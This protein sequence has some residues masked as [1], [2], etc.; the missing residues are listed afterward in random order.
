[1][2]QLQF[3]TIAVSVDFHADNVNTTPILRWA[4]KAPSYC[5]VTSFNAVLTS[6]A[7]LPEARLYNY[8]TAGTASAGTVSALIDNFTANIP[9]TGAITDAIVQSG[10]WL[11]VEFANIAGW[12]GGSSAQAV[13]NLQ[14]GLATDI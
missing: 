7:G 14:Y 12:A 13:I 8:G 10:E 3:D 2:A 1:M 9:K 11:V 6:G 5:T 4:I